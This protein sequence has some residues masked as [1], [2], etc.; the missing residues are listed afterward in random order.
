MIRRSNFGDL[1]LGR[2]SFGFRHG[3][4]EWLSGITVYRDGNREHCL[5]TARDAM[6]REAGALLE[7]QI[8][9]GG[10]RRLRGIGTGRFLPVP[11]MAAL[12]FP[13]P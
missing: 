13:R 10:S 1:A 9:E 3:I 4:R 8:T 2:G 12:R 6:R 11:V 5:H 7:A